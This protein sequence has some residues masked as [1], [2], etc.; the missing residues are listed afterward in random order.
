[1]TYETVI[2]KGYPFTNET[3]RLDPATVANDYSF[4]NLYKWANE[5]V[6]ADGAIVQV[7]RL[8]DLYFVDEVNVAYRYLLARWKGRW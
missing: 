4:L 3:M 5:T 2:A 8:D 6:I 7:N 1:M